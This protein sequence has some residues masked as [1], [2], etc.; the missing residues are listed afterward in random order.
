MLGKTV[1]CEF[2]GAY[3]NVTTN[4]LDPARTPGGSSS[5]SAAAVADFMVPIAF[6]TQTGGSVLRP[7]SFCGLVGYKPTFGGY[8]RE[9]LRFAAESFDTIGLISRTVEDAAY[10]DDV[11]RGSSPAMLPPLEV[12]PRVGLCRT[13]MWDIAQA[14]THACV[15]RTVRKTG[16]GR[17]ERRG[18]RTARALLRPHA[19]ARDHQ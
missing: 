3:P 16:S 2:A 12:A 9:G 19:G 14:E 17:R 4:P 6:G 11:L 18:I 7:A 8:N 15:A 1:T 10:C 5:G 13:Y